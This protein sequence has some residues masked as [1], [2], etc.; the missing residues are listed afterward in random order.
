M[1]KDTYA[2]AI[3]LLELIANSLHDREQKNNQNISFTIKEVQIVE[4]WLKNF[5]KK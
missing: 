4:K 3:N 2:E 1:K 5:V